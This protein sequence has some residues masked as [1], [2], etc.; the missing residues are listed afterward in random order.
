MVLCIF[1]QFSIGLDPS[2]H[3]RLSS[4]M[5][6]QFSLVFG[7]LRLFYLFLG[8]VNSDILIIVWASRL[9]FNL[10]IKPSVFLPQGFYQLSALGSR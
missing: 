10:L 2:L 6:D 9:V 3:Y 7:T 8:E 5:V 1:G 4:L